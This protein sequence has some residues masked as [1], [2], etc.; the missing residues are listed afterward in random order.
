[1]NQEQYQM[2]PPASNRPMTNEGLLRFVSVEFLFTIVIGVFAGGTA[3][4]TLKASA[5]EVERDV[6]ELQTEQKELRE[7]Q[8]EIKEGV[9]QIRVDVAQISTN[10][11]HFR[12]DI[13]K[14]EDNLQLI[15]QEIRQLERPQ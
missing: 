4:A 14:I 5:E 2:A 3:W 8:Y 7:A 9:A 6:I 1:M 15:L 12:K 10:Q 13:D 11:G